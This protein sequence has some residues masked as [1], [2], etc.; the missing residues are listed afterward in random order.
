MRRYTLTHSF[1]LQEASFLAGVLAG[2]VS[3][4]NTNRSGT[5]GIIGSVETD[6]T[7]IQLIAGFK[8]GFYYANNTLNC[9][10]TLL[11][12]EYVGSYNDSANAEQLA[13][14]MFDPDG[15]NADIIFAPVRASIMGIRS[16]MVYANETWF[17]NTTNREPFV[18]AAEGNQDYLGLPNIDTRS[19]YSWVLTSVVPRSDLAVYRVINATMWDKFQGTTLQYRIDNETDLPE[20]TLPIMRSMNDIGVNL[21]NFEFNNEAWVPLSTLRTIESLRTQIFFGSII[22]NATYT[23]MSSMHG[24]NVKQTNFNYNDEAWVPPS[25]LERIGTVRA[26]VFYGT[27]PV[28]ATFLS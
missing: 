14:D 15:G 20:G 22:V 25:T 8:Q 3:S 24:I 1:A 27:I 12:D 10:V 16:A 9:T 4:S 28:F 6:P 26:Q 7:V 21:T 2:M 13:K 23:P 5:V 18:I 19:G 11:P 17:C